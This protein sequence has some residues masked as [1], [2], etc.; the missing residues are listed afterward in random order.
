MTM[1]KHISI[2]HANMLTVAVD[3]SMDIKLSVALI[4]Y[5][6]PKKVEI[7]WKYVLFNGPFFSGA[8]L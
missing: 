4:I 1:C 2:H 8:N 5:K 7:H 3:L 6:C